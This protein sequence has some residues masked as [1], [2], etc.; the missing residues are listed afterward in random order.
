MLK[1]E[2]QISGCVRIKVFLK[3]LQ[4]QPFSKIQRTL[5]QA[6][7]TAILEKH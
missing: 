1:L 3:I 7:L 5:R 6:D 4:T 2:T